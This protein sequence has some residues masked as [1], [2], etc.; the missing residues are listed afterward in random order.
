MNVMHRTFLK[1]LFV[2]MESLKDELE[3]LINSLD[4]RLARRE[5]TAYVRNENIAVLRNEVMGLEDFIRGCPEFDFSGAET[6]QDMADMCKEYL[7]GRLREHDYVPAVYRLVAHRLDKIASYLSVDD[8][9]SV[10]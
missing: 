6:P 3:I 10:V 1:L 5:I 4:N 7:H 2:E 8:D 9:A